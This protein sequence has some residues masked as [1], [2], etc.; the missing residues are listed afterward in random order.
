[1]ASTIAQLPKY[2][3]FMKSEIYANQRTRALV[4]QDKAFGTWAL[5][6]SDVG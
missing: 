1:M 4:R 2:R 3:K 6:C 5:P